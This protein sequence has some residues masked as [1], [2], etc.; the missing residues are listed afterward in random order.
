MKCFL[1]LAVVAPFSLSAVPAQIQVPQKVGQQ[2]DVI[3]SSE[4]V[5]EGKLAGCVGGVCSMDNVS[6]ARSRIVWIGLKVDVRLPPVPTD[7]ARDEVRYRDGSV[8]PGRLVG[9]N[10]NLVVTER[11]RHQRATVSWIYLAPQR[12]TGNAPGQIGAPQQEPGDTVIKDPKKTNT[13]GDAPTDTLQPG[14]PPGGKRGGLWTGKITQRFVKREQGVL[15]ITTTIDDVRLREYVQPISV[16]ES[17]K[18][19]Q[20]GTVTS[21]VAEGGRISERLRDLHI[22]DY[23]GPGGRQCNSSGEGTTTLTGVNVSTSFIWKKNVN[24]DT[25]TGVGWNVPA[26]PGLYFVGLSIHTLGGYTRSGTCVDKDGT[27]VISEEE[28]LHTVTFGRL[29]PQPVTFELDPELR[30]LDSAGSRMIGTYT[31]TGRPGKN[32]VSWSIC[33][34]GVR[35]AAPPAAADG[36]SVSLGNLFEAD[37]NLLLDEAKPKLDGLLSRIQADPGLMPEIRVIVKEG[38]D[39]L[40]LETLGKAQIDALK[41]WF[42]ERGVD[43][44]RIAWTWETGASDQVLIAYD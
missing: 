20:V 6:T 5:R 27:S 4:G 38:G 16:V 19:R 43:A 14:P 11:G 39:P 21:L 13:V 30:I 28:N 40:F 25:T 26:G 1:L 3:V 22:E 10:A 33:R 9:I 37:L 44:S 23:G 15:R 2:K 32:T 41:A 42:A 36:T 17:G 34:E 7:S 8:H 24:V 29:P 12:E 35:C 31:N 18:L